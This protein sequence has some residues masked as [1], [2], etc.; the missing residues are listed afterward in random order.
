[1]ALDADAVRREPNHLGATPVYLPAPQQTLTGG[2]TT[3]DGIVLA[4][5]DNVRGRAAIYT[6]LDVTANNM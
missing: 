4:Y 2:R 5:L 3:R 1:M 6:K